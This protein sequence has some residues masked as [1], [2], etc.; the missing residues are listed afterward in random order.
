MAV[1]AV[2]VGAVVAA[3]ANV[4][5][6]A[7]DVGPAVVGAAV[8]EV[9]AAVVVVAAEVVVTEGVGLS[10]GAAHGPLEMTLV[11]SVTAPLR[12][13]SCPITDAPVFAVIEVS[14]KMCPIKR[15]RFSVNSACASQAMVL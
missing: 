13:R 7:V 12:A 5:G 9:G 11:S 14:A 2:V 15:E 6:A 1:V 8:V 10:V 4:V 3:G